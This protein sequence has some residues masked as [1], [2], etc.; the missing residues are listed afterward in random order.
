[1]SRAAKNTTSVPNSVDS[2]SKAVWISG[3][4]PG[5]EY[6][7]VITRFTSSLSSRAR[8]PRSAM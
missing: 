4:M 1:L 7:R 8:A 5:C 2:S 3:R 6:A